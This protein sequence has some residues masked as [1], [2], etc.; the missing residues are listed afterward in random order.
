MIS[1]EL[2]FAEGDLY[3]R[4]GGFDTKVF[5][6][7]QK[8]TG[9]DKGKT[10]KLLRKICQAQLDLF[11]TTAEDDAKL[12]QSEEIS[13]SSRLSI[14]IRYRRCKKILLQNIMKTWENKS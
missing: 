10:I 13:N 2:G 14:A 1:K 12:L 11:D 5:R 9:G 6:A 8:R 4:K 3:A 7:V